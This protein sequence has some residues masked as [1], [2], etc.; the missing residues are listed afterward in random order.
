MFGGTGS[1]LTYAQIQQDI[2]LINEV[3]ANYIRGV[4]HFCLVLKLKMK[5]YTINKKKGTLSTRS[6]ILRSL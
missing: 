1:A 3:G 4:C 6:K 2:A 5:I